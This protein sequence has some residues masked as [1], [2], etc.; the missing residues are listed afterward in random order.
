MRVE[1]KYIQETDLRMVDKSTCKKAGIGFVPVNM[2][3]WVLSLQPPWPVPFHFVQRF[4]KWIPC[5]HMNIYIQPLHKEI[6]YHSRNLIL[7]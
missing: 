4:I 5:N 2:P 6:I 3:G 1:L 7:I